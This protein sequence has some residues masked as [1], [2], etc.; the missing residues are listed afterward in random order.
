[1]LYSW[2]KGWG[3]WLW[4]FCCFLCCNRLLPAV[5][6]I[7]SGEGCQPK[8]RAVLWRTFSAPLQ[9][10]A[11]ETEGICFPSSLGVVREPP[12]RDL[13]P[14]SEQPHFLLL[15]PSQAAQGVCRASFFLLGRSGLSILT[16]RNSGPQRFSPHHT[17]PFGCLVL[18]E[19]G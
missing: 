1:M 9:S 19:E 17:W 18:W 8:I 6:V 13:P 7:A 5:R 10:T 4:R 11:S 16:W 3:H 15:D 2:L 14:A 12:G